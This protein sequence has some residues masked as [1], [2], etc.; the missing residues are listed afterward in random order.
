MRFLE[1][2]IEGNNNRIGLYSGTKAENTKIRGSNN[3]LF[4]GDYSNVDIKGSYNYL[5]GYV[6]KSNIFGSN[7]SIP[8][9]SE[10]ITIDYGC[11]N[12]TIQTSTQGSSSNY[13]QNIHIHSGVEGPSSLNKKTIT[14]DRNLSYEINIVPEGTTIIEV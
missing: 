8:N 12:I 7:M 14:V 2:I 10:N 9:Y 1:S 11:S 3:D 6:L 4:K 5:Y 13:L